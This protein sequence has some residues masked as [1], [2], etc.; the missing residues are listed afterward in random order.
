MHWDIEAL[1]REFHA[2]RNPKADSSFFL[3]QL[4][5]LVK[6]ANALRNFFELEHVHRWSVGAE[7]EPSFQ[8]L[9]AARKEVMRVCGVH[10]EPRK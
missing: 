4:A 1:N 10:K 9:Q 5:D 8:A 6:Q 7:V 3:N 2:A